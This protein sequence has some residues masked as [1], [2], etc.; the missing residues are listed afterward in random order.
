LQRIL[1]QERENED[2]QLLKA[3]AKQLE[4]L[5]HF[6]VQC[7]QKLFSSFTYLPTKVDITKEAEGSQCLIDVDSKV[8]YVVIT[9]SNAN[10]A[11]AVQLNSFLGNPIKDRLC[12]EGMI[13]NS[14]GQPLQVQEES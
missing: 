1:T 3:V 4:K 8:I 14:P 11:L 12:L 13:A 10:G 7:V 9:A 6:R 5:H 2:Q